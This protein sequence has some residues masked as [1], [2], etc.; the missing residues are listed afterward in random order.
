MI[1]VF[2]KITSREAFASNVEEMVYDARLFWS[3]LEDPAN[4]E[5]WFENQHPKEYE[6]LRSSP[7][8]ATGA[9]STEEQYAIGKKRLADSV[10]EYSKLLGKQN[11]IF[12]GKEDL[13][14][15]SS[16]F[17]QLHNLKSVIVLDPF[18]AHSDCHPFHWY[19]HE[20]EWFLQWSEKAFK[21]IAS[22][23]RW[24]IA[25]YMDHGIPVMEAP[26][27]FRGINNLLTVIGEQAPQLRHLS[28]GCQRS[29]LSGMIFDRKENVKALRKVSSQLISF[30]I[31]CRM[32]NTEEHL[33][34][35][36]RV[37]AANHIIKDAKHLKSLALT[38]DGSMTDW[39][40][41]HEGNMSSS[42]NI[43]DLCA[44]DI[45][46]EALQ[47]ILI[48][49]G[50]TL[51]ELR[52]CNMHLKDQHSWEEVSGEIGQYLRLHC[53]TLSYISDELGCLSGALSSRD[54]RRAVETAIN[55]MQRTPHQFQKITGGGAGIVMAW[56]SETFRP[57]FDLDSY[58]DHFFSYEDIFRQ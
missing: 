56:N 17:Q 11:S 52:L 20:F 3:Y 9:G 4:Y 23:T 38:L 55:F 24:S 25:D 1:D 29:C 5:K 41:F 22:P 50:E 10:R 13:E 54:G 44:G 46:I 12:N 31:H 33:L 34:V 47:A 39:T 57:G 53:I 8:I 35:S 58:Y 26:W 36:D 2:V 7:V 6:S 21:D 30:K 15:L 43:L 28:F 19:P 49:H 27:D 45:D 40:K 14:A 51:S 16:G 42:L 48:A 37:D 18:E 32:P